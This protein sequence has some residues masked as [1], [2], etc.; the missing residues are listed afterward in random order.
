M[1]LGFRILRQG[2]QEEEEDRQ[3]EARRLAAKK[4]F[5]K[6]TAKTKPQAKTKQYCG[7][8]GAIVLAVSKKQRHEE[9]AKKQRT[10]QEESHQK[11]P[12]FMDGER[13]PYVPTRE[14]FWESIRNS[15][16]FDGGEDPRRWAPHGD[17][18]AQDEELRDAVENAD[19]G[20]DDGRPGG[21]PRGLQFGAMPESYGPR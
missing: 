10:A 12:G 18:E 11:V 2:L 19:E 14:E 4:Q 3:D 6:M 16:D 17:D 9:A 13:V 8:D 21:S 20:W 15:E 7:Q 5:K 1:D